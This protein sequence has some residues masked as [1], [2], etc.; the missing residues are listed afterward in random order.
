[1]HCVIRHTI[2]KAT[3][4]IYKFEQSLALMKDSFKSCRAANDFVIS[5][6]D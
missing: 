2:N 3:V 4:K 5:E 6:F 1:M